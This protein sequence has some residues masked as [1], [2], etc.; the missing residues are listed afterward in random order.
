MSGVQMSSEGSSLQ[1]LR[2]FDNL[3]EIKLWRSAL[4]CILWLLSSSI[5]TPLISIGMDLIGSLWLLKIFLC[6][7]SI[8]KYGTHLVEWHSLWLGA[9][10]CLVFV[11]M[12]TDFLNGNDRCPPILGRQL[13]MG[14]SVPDIR[15]PLSSYIF[16]WYFVFAMAHA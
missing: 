16:L 14:D 5:L 8:W 1:G 13:C 3:S 4:L 2:L 7:S 9:S 10:N 11:H 6:S 15:N 12:L